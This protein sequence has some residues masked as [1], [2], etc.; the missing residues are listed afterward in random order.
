MKILKG[1][2]VSLVICCCLLGFSGC[3]DGH[4]HS[5]GGWT[6]IQNAKCDETGTRQKECKCGDIVTDI[7]PQLG[8]NF[9]GG[10]CT[11]CGANE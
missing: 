1:F 6:I 10:T 2:A 4:K 5:Y 8:H 7:I 9:V 3:D 11:D